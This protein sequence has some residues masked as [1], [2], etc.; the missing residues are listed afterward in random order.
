MLNNIAQQ[1][2]TS[3][4]RKKSLNQDDPN[5]Y[6]V[7]IALDNSLR[8]IPYKADEIVLRK[9]YNCNTDREEY[10]VGSQ[11]TSQKDLHNLFESA[12]FSLSSASQF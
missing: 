3:Q 4:Q 7:E 2:S 8:K 11:A 6:W 12:G 1:T 9:S 10:H 5:T